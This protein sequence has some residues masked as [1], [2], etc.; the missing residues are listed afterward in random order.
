MLWTIGIFVYWV[1][2]MTL[3]AIVILWEEDE[4]LTK[5]MVTMGVI[6]WPVVL[7]SILIQLIA[8]L[9]VFMVNAPFLIADWYKRRRDE[10]IDGT[11]HE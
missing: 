3:M 2:G 9:L 5:P 1:V 4:V 6:L 11:T 7:C 8:F 10:W